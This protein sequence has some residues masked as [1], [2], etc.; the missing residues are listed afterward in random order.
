MA[1]PAGYFSLL[2]KLY[3]KTYKIYVSRLNYMQII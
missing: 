3:A 2:L 1:L